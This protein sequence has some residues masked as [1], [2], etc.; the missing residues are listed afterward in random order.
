[1]LFL[2]C[3]TLS[4]QKITKTT[5]RSAAQW[6]CTISSRKTFGQSVFSF[7]ASHQLNSVSQSTSLSASYCSFKDKVKKW[8]LE[9]QECQHWSCTCLLSL[10]SFVVTILYLFLACILQYT[11]K[12]V[13]LLFLFCQ[14][15]PSKRTANENKPFFCKLGCI[16]LCMNDN[17][18]YRYIASFQINE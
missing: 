7:S 11:L 12:H 5:T 17:Y 15:T 16:Y 4:L 18:R 14:I 10:L 6:K 9:E 13:V 1:M 2:L 3:Q 8:L